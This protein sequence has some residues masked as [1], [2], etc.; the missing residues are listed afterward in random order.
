MEMHW[1]NYLA[2]M[3]LN[4]SSKRITC[5][6]KAFF[7]GMLAGLDTASNLLSRKD[8]INIDQL[9]LDGMVIA[10]RDII[11]HQPEEDN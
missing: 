10:A 7:T 1:Q 5:A 3:P 6:R 9:I 2:G 8:Q 4:A 11:S